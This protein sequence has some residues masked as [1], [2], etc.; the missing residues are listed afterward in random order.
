MSIVGFGHRNF[1]DLST[2]SPLRRIIIGGR[3]LC[4]ISLMYTVLSMVRIVE[5]PV[6]VQSY[7]T[8]AWT[9]GTSG[10]M[11]KSSEKEVTLTVISVLYKIIVFYQLIESRHDNLVLFWKW[12][13][14]KM[15]LKY[16]ALLLYVAQMQR[17]F[18]IRPL[19]QL[20][21]LPSRFNVSDLIV[22]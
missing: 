18:L 8:S 14:M 13:Q 6:M 11:P 7:V 1:G 2:S 19:Y 21:Q 3:R 10:F 17:I 12:N 15:M 5:L 16:S 20:H 9:T 4:Y 22:G